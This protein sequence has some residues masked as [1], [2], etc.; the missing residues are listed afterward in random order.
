MCNPQIVLLRGKRKNH[1]HKLLKHHQSCHGGA[2]L[3]PSTLEAEDMDLWEFKASLSTL[4]VIDQP[5]L[6]RETV[7]QNNDTINKEIRPYPPGSYKRC[8]L[9]CYSTWTGIEWIIFN[10]RHGGFC[11]LFLNTETHR[12]HLRKQMPVPQLASLSSPGALILQSLFCALWLHGARGFGRDVI[13]HIS[14]FWRDIDN[15][16]PQTENEFNL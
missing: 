3:N 1:R 13:F 10:K 12:P 9:C 15:S 2:V 6:H 16:T 14:V 8:R 4:W 5:G 11:C 7:S